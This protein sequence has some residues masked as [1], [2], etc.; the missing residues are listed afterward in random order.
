[1]FNRIRTFISEL[2]GRKTHITR[3]KSNT[4]SWSTTPTLDI[5]RSDYAFWDKARRAKTDGLD[6]SGLLIKPLNSKI[7]AWVLGVI[8]KWKVPKSE[9]TQQD[10]NEWWRLNQPTIVR[11]FEESLNLGDSYI[12]LQYEDKRIHP[13]VLSPNVIDPI[14]DP[15][16]YSKILGWRIKETYKNPD[17]VNDSMSIV[18]E[19]YDTHHIREV[20]KDGSLRSRTRYRNLIGKNP[21]IHIP[22]ITGSDEL[23]GRPEAEPLLSTLQRYNTVLVA[24][25][26][27]NIHQ[28]RPTPVAIFERQ[29]EV[30]AFFNKYATRQTRTLNDGTTETYYTIDFTSDDFLAL[31]AKDFKYAQPGSFASDTE[32]L[33]GLLF[34]LLIQYSEIPEFAWGNAVTS[35]KASSDIQLVPF[36]RWIEKRRGYVSGWLIELSNTVLALMNLSNA[37]IKP[38][39]DLRINWDRLTDKDDRL[40]LDAISWAF[41]S[42]I[43]LL[44]EETALSLLPLKVDDPVEVLE[45]AQKDWEERHLK[46]IERAAAMAPPEDGGED[47]SKARSG[48]GRRSGDGGEPNPNRDVDVNNTGDAT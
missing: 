18:D 9:R 24:G 42:E 10:L 21:I 44:D 40:T 17:D 29:Q 45:K 46:A 34:Y 38:Q 32:K 25:L 6:I 19:W 47:S 26:D 5:S 37:W 27:G 48:P 36:A 12:L 16:D 1:M 39:K 20:W 35:S 7:A 4:N 2:I 41:S 15:D 3:F 14:V 31:A 33:L 13:V 22:N 43:A 28:G 8:P 30:Q 11:A 23:F